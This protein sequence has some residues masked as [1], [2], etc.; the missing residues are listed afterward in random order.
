MNKKLIIFALLAFVI[1]SIT[2]FYVLKY[3]IVGTK[4]EST[5]KEPIDV[6]TCDEMNTYDLKNICL[7]IFTNDPSK[8]KDAG[9]FDTYC[10][11]TVFGVIKDVS[12]SLCKSFSEYYPRTTCYFELAKIKKD[13]SLCEESGGRY[14]KCSWELAKIL[15][16]P[17]LCEN[18]GVDSEKKECLAEV[19]CNVSFCKEITNEE[20]KKICIDSLSKHVS[21]NICKE[22]IPEYPSVFYIPE[23]VKNVAITTQNISLCN[24][25]D[26]KETKWGCFA[27]V[28]KSIDVC[29][30]ADNI[31]WMDFCKVEF[32][33]NIFTKKSNINYGK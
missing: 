20:E 28:S 2:V 11:D 5:K 13:P 25:I 18:I 8:C 27:E 14:Q 29:E 33:K 15:K 6:K 10:Y 19:T 26:V 4:G 16:K 1:I 23:C 31:F 24:L 30:R 9:N 7:A 17:E 3:G 22:Y 21:I 32:I 12:E